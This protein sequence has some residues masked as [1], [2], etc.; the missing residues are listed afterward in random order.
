VFYLL[1]DEEGRR[2]LVPLLLEKG[3]DVNASWSYEPVTSLMHAIR[4]K[5]E[6]LIRLFLDAGANVDALIYSKVDG[7]IKRSV[8]RD[9]ESSGLAWLLPEI[10]KRSDPR[11]REETKLEEHGRIKLA[12]EE[13]ERR[14]ARDYA[15]AT[16]RLHEKLARL[17]KSDDHRRWSGSVHGPVELDEMM[18]VLEK[19]KVIGHDDSSRS[20]SYRIT[21]LVSTGS[22]WA[23]DGATIES[24][25]LELGRSAE[26]FFYHTYETSRLD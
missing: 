24:T 19:L 13:K 14:K 20:S 12:D 25:W 11:K 8:R 26:G 22:R 6:V 16:Y 9:A 17:G 5:D 1:E 3:A 15:D 23:E 2:T 4:A 21:F 10:D 7:K 18:Q